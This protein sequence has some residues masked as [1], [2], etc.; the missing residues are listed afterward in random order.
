MRIIKAEYLKGAVDKN[1][2]PEEIYPEVVFCGRSNVGKSSLINMLTNKKN[3][4]RTSQVPGKTQLL[5]FFNINDMLYFVDF[6]GYGYAK[7][8]KDMKKQFGKMIEE[9]IKNREALR[10][11]FL[12]VDMRHK[13]T[14]DDVLMYEFLKYHDLNIKVI[15]T[16]CDKIKNS[17]RK[18]CID[19]ILNTLN[20]TKEDLIITS[21]EKR[22]GFDLILGELDKVINE[23]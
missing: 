15:A 21:S 12:L 22:I 1:S 17:E 19:N 18:E 5:N 20:I 16:K 13:P 4:A 8:S 6:P 7:V 2:W 14:E 23:E 9:Y 10:L 11:V 3:L